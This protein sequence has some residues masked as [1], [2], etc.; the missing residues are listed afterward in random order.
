M[1]RL[2]GGREIPTEAAELADRMRQPSVDPRLDDLRRRYRGD[3][4]AA[5]RAALAAL[6][7][8]ERN[9]LRQHHMDG[10]TIDQLAG[11]YR[12]HRAT[13]AR[14]VARARTT[15]SGETR[16]RLMERLGVATQ[17]ADSIIR[18]VRSQLDLSLSAAPGPASDRD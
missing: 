2:G 18:L 6:P 1:R 16:R 5:F 11:L 10:L 8:R 7:V 13:A 15:L 12:V 17:D 4:A 9:L 3:F 14:W